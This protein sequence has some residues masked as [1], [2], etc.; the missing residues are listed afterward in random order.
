MSLRE[1]ERERERAQ[2]RLEDMKI[3]RRDQ[4]LIETTRRERKI[5]DFLTFFCLCPFLSARFPH[6]LSIFIINLNSFPLKLL[7]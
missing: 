3:L 1:R 5:I 4:L 7:F 2:V 6:S